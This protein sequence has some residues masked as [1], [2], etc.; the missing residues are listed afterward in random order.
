MVSLTLS[1]AVMVT[2]NTQSV[3]AHEWMSRYLLHLL[4]LPRIPL[5][6]FIDTRCVCIMRV[7]YGYVVPNLRDTIQLDLRSGTVDLTRDIYYPQI[8]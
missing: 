1:V 8:L 5:R 3:S 6:S 7:E 4:S 2:T